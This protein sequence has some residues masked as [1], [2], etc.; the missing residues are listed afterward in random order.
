M[1]TDKVKLTASIPFALYD[2]I[3]TLAS[4]NHMTLTKL[5]EEALRCYY[6]AWDRRRKIAA[7]EARQAK[8]GVS[9]E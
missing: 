6:D 2:Q 3:H 1:N 9:A 7:Y 8:V 5:T 4:M